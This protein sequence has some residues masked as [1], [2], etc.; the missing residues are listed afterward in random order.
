MMRVGASYLAISSYALRYV[1]VVDLN[2]R[3]QNLSSFRDL[4]K[5]T[6]FYLQ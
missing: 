1:T 6:A 4:R 5:I 2:E 3:R